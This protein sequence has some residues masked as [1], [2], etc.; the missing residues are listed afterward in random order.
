MRHAQQY[1]RLSGASNYGAV[2]SRSSTDTPTHHK[3]GA[4]TSRDSAPLAAANTSAATAAV[5]SVV[6]TSTAPAGFSSSSPYCNESVDDGDGIGTPYFRTSTE[7]DYGS[8]YGSRG[9]M[10]MAQL[11]G[12]GSCVPGIPGVRYRTE[13][14]GRSTRYQTDDDSD[15]DEKA[16]NRRSCVGGGVV[17]DGASSNPPSKYAPHDS[18]W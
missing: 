14:G 17:Y 3:Y 7:T 11:H 8:L 18:T 15:D 10:D 9:S 16:R 1:N 12:I 5:T 6:P 4:S 13:R 2:S